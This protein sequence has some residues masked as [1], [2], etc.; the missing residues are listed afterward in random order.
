MVKNASYITGVKLDDMK[1]IY[2][3]RMKKRVDNIVQDIHHPATNE[4]FHLMPSG[5]RMRS[6]SAKTDRLKNSFIPS[7]VRVFNNLNFYCID[8]CNYSFNC[9]VC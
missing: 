3:K 6:I 8:V 2:G 1:T 5:R 9:I 7:A 4:F